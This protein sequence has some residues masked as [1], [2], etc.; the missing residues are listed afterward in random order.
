[1]EGSQEHIYKLANPDLII[2][3]K[4]PLIIGVFR[5][6]RRFFK[7]KKLIGKNICSNLPVQA[8]HYRKPTLSKILDWHKCNKN[9]KSE[10][11]K[12]LEN[13]TSYI[14]IKNFKEYSKV[15]DILD[16]NKDL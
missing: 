13:K 14:T 12:H 2:Y 8:Y 15:Y 6:V 7:A 11:E 9:I 16:E 4:I 10:I 5:F 1:M 3:M